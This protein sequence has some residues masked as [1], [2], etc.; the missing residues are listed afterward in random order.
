MSALQ[1]RVCGRT[2]TGLVHEANEDHI[3][4]GRLIENR[5]RVELALS[6]DN[7]FLVRRGLL[8]AV[9]DGIGG[10][11][12]GAG[13]SRAALEVLDERFYQRR[14]GES[15]P[16]GI[17][18]AVRRAAAA[19]NDELLR[20]VA[21]EPGSEGGGCTLCGVCLTGDG[22]FVFNAGDSRAYRFRGAYLKALTRDDSPV[23]MAVE[24]G[25]MSRSEA[26]RSAA[27]H[28]LTNYLG[29]AGFRLAMEAGPPLKS[30]DLLLLCS[31]GLHG[32]V[33]LE[34]MEEVLRTGLPVEA[35]VDALLEKAIDG[36][37]RDDV[38]VILV[39]VLEGRVGTRDGA[40]P[41]HEGDR[42]TESRGG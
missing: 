25:M 37:A 1:L 21:G 35:A 30:G 33:E 7:D 8:L 3:L 12:G 11:A 27:G 14:A 34:S 41:A 39:S 32:A 40:S 28:G 42:Q 22:F 15:G 24:A 31:D 9:A 13:A 19:A 10:L 29:A 5:G 20:R 36:G 38:S 6:A 17:E 2:E 18:A 23:G 26:A 16:Q 4:L